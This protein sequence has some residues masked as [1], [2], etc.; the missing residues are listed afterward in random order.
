MTR[1]QV[2]NSLKPEDGYGQKWRLILQ[3]CRY[4]YDD[5]S[6]EHGYRLIRVSPERKLQP[7]RGQ[8][9]LPSL[10]I[11]QELMA[12]AK[13]LAYWRRALFP[14]VLALEQREPAPDRSTHGRPQIMVFRRCGNP[15][16]SVQ[17]RLASPTGHIQGAAL[18][19][20]RLGW[21]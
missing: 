16:S 8:A 7:V 3:W 18:A 4:L 19:F 2:V 10:K 13:A 15:A 5:G 12:K 14:L 21:V 11:A 20:P 6:K 17:P 9:R 1:I